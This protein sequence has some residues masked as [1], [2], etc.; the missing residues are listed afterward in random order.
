[1]EILELVVAI[2]IIVLL[3]PIITHI[4]G[5]FIDIIPSSLLFFLTLLISLKIILFIIHRGDEG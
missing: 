1:M 2:L 3:L 4:T 5:F